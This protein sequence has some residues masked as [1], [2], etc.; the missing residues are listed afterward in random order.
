MKIKQIN[1]LIGSV[2]LA[3]NCCVWYPSTSA[4]QNLIA[5]DSLFNR[6]DSLLAQSKFDEARKTYQAVLKIDKNLIR[7]YAGLGKIAVAEQKWGDAGDE[8]QR[9]LD[10]DP[11]NFEAHYYRGI[12]TRETGKFKVLLLRKLDWDKSKKHFQWVLDRDSL[13]N[14]VVYQLALLKRYQ[15]NYQ[16]AIRLGHIQIRLQPELVEPQVKLFRFY[17][18][19][20]SHT[21]KE[22]AIDWLKQQA[23]DHARWAIAEK[24]RREGLLNQADSVL[25]DL[26][27]RPTTMSRQPVYLSLIRI[28]FKQNLQHQAEGCFW[29][30]INEINDDIDANLIFEDVKYILTDQELDS[31]LSL[32]TIQ[33]KIDFFKKVWISR[34]PTPAASLN[35]RL[36]EHYRRLM[37]AEEN[38]EFDGFRTWFNNPDKYGYLDFTRTYHLNEE[39][40]DKGLIYIRHG[41]YNDW[42]R[43]ISEDVPSNETWVY[44][45]TQTTPKMVFHFLMENTA[46]YWRF[47]PI[48]TDPRMLEDRVGF[49]NIYYRMLRA[50]PLERLAYEEEMARDSREFVTAGLSTDRHSWEKKIKSL[51]IPFSMATFRGKEGKTTLEIYNAFSFSELSEKTDNQDVEIEKGL[52]IH[53]LAWQPIEKYQETMSVPARKSESYIDL[54]RFEVVPDSYH[55]AFYLRPIETD[56]LGGWKYEKQIPDYS[57]PALSISDIQLA[58]K[59]EAATSPGRFVKHGLRVTPN[60]TRLCDIKQPV[61]L[62]FEIYQL[63]QDARGTTAFTIEYKLTLLEQTRKGLFGLFGR[64]GKSSISTQIEREGKTEISIEYLAID[65]SQLKPGEYKLEIL[66]TDRQNGRVTTQQRRIAL[67]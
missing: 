21:E 9:V 18:Y 55:L 45:Q 39:F 62:Y 29:Q 57:S 16:E 67:K 31:Y 63:T 44:Y 6:A 4:T 22:E 14:D 23:R 37:Y 50:S 61:Y 13:F 30:A 48:I 10:K 64:G 58:S 53:N 47:T 26:L 42:A 65:V 19:F 12:C 3:I 54:Y 56:F 34:D 33:E 8:F 49:G 52:T 36:A 27:N 35:Y 11:E 41:Q 2:I 1:Y 38:F 51:E 5:V 20:I 28:Y 17:R 24:Y 43:T 66:V 15:E 40:N 60:P 59:I 32:I 25:L 46:G 7:A